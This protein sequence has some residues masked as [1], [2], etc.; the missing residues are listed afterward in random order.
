MTKSQKDHLRIG[1]QVGED[2]WDIGGGG[3]KHVGQNIYIQ[4]KN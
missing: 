4:T 3:A 1:Y 2:K